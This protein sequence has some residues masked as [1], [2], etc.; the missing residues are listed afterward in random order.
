M[1]Y[2]LGGNLGGIEAQ[3]EGDTPKVPL[4]D[5]AIRAAKP[6]EKPYEPS[7]GEGLHLAIQPNGSKLWRMKYRFAGKEN[8]LSFG[9]YPIVG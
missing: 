8:R 1:P 2:E 3:R 7:D 5:F 4:N 6:Q 9:Q